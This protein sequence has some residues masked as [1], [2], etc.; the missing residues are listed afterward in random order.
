M[1]RHENLRPASDHAEPVFEGE[2][3]CHQ[4][5]EEAGCLQR[6]KMAHQKSKRR[7]SMRSIRINHVATF[8]LDN[9]GRE[10]SHHAMEYRD[11]DPGIGDYGEDGE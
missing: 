1:R 3:R 11:L 2:G 6:W 9:Y 4:G 10:G 7:S 5:S 8:L